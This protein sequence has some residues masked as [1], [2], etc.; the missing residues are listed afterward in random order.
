MKDQWR[1]WW[2]GLAP[3]ERRAVS[4]GV[5]AVLALL[6][7]AGIWQPLAEANTRLRERVA[8]HQTVLAWM[9]AHAAEVEALRERAGADASGPSGGSL[10]GLVDSTAKSAGLAGRLRRVE[11]EGDTAVRLWVEQAPFDD[12]VGWLG[13]LDAEHGLVVRRLTLRRDDAPGTVTGRLLIR[14]PP[15]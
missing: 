7:Y 14:G 2:E 6:V 10:L 11:P 1:S 15:G 13:R 5:A 12:L 4:A 9:R 8:E 3:R